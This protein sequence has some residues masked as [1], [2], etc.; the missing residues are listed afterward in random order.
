MTSGTRA[1]D[2]NDRVTRAYREAQ[3]VSSAEVHASDAELSELAG[4][5]KGV[6]EHVPDY[7]EAI[8]AATRVA[9]R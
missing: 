2:P 9:G 6:L 7:R 8:G 1:E 4:N 5:W 3:T